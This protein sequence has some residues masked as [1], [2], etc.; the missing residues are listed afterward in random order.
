MMTLFDIFP[1]VIPYSSKRPEPLR[2]LIDAAKMAKESR[3][4]ARLGSTVRSTVTFQPLARDMQNSF[5]VSD[6]NFKDAFLGSDTT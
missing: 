2:P 3:H 1:Y 4:L 6:S 5:T